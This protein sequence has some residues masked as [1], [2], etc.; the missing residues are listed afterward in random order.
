MFCRILHYFVAKSFFCDLRCFVAKSVL[1]RFARFC[2]EKN[3]AKSCARG[4]KMTNM[5]YDPW[6]SSASSKPL[7]YGEVA[8]GRLE[9]FLICKIFVLNICVFWYSYFVW[10]LFQTFCV[11]WYFDAKMI[12]FGGYIPN[13]S[14]PRESLGT[15]G[16]GPGGWNDGW[17]ASREKEIQISW[18]LCTSLAEIKLSWHLGTSL[19]A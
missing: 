6:P 12:E 17:T 5:R 1:V 10:F 19:A 14:N 2:V 16:S 9:F 3:W 11:F 18:H 13:N 8:M 15:P 7:H 4:E